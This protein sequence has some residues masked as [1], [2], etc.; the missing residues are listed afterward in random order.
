M[1][2]ELQN[3]SRGSCCRCD[4][5]LSIT[6]APS[7]KCKDSAKV[8][9]LVSWPGMNNRVKRKCVQEVDILKK[10]NNEEGV[11]KVLERCKE[12]GIYTAESFLRAADLCGKDFSKAAVRALSTALDLLLM[13]EIAGSYSTLAEVKLKMLIEAYCKAWLSNCSLSACSFIRMV[14]GFCNDESHVGLPSCRWLI[15]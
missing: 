13:Y 11:L 4:F 2:G 3:S 14:D 9:A 1:S 5:Y 7:V 6:A 10:M 8:S 12:D 15:I